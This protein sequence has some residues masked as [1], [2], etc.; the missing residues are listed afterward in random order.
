VRRS[1]D[2]GDPGDL[3]AIVIKRLFP[4]E[5]L[6]EFLPYFNDVEQ[7][8]LIAAMDPQLA[9]IM[10]DSEFPQFLSEF[11]KEM[12]ANDEEEPAPEPSA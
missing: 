2:H 3:A 12:K 4:E 9:E 7:L 11:V 1:F 8:K 6:K 5:Q 10:G